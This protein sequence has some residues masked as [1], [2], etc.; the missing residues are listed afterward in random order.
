MPFPFRNSCRANRPSRGPASY[1]DP[2][3][4]RSELGRDCLDIAEQ[5]LVAEGWLSEEEI[6][7]RRAGL[8]AAIDE[9]ISTV[10][11][12]SAPDASSESWQALSTASLRDTSS[13]MEVA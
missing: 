6:G 11:R 13:G 12:E 10:Q 8:V 9:T 2:K 7:R 3:L 4:K 5:R 1:I